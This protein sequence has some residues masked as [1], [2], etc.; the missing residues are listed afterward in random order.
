MK[1]RYSYHSAHNAATTD[2]WRHFIVFVGALL[3]LVAATVELYRYFT[4][5]GDADPHWWELILGVGYLVVGLALAVF[6]Y[7]MAN[8]SDGAEDRFVRVGED[9]LRWHLCQQDGEESLPLA[10][11]QSVE[12]VNVRDLKISHVGG[13]TMLPIYLVA[14]GGKQEELLRVLTE[15]AGR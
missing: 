3:L 15:V 8:A 7:R 5:W 6:G 13:E 1:L 14:D 10:D 9:T 2:R 4:H 11:I 12:R